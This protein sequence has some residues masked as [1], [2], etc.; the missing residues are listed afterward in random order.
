MQLKSTVNPPDV[1][2]ELGME[3][4]LPDFAM[5]KINVYMQIVFSADAS[6]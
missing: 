5:E 2:W 3:Q 4:C 1:P 6:L